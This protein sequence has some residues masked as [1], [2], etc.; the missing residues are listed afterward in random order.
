VQICHGRHRKTEAAWVAEYKL[1][2]QIHT[3]AQSMA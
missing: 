1:L 2:D 3:C